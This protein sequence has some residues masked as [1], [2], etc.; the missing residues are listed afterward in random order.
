MNGDR[1]QRHSLIEWFS[2]ER[3]AR[4]RVVVVGAGAVGNEVIKN[5]ALLGVGEIQIYDIDQI[6]EHNLT[7]SVLFREADIGIPKATV[8]AQRAMELDRNV[9]ATPIVA[10]FWDHL[11]IAELQAFDLLLCCVDNFEARIRCNMISQI[12]RTDFVNV[13]IDSRFALVELFPFSEHAD[14]GCYECNLPPSVYRRMA[15]RYSCGHLRKLSL[16]ERKVPTTIITSTIAGS[17]AV[18]AGLRLGADS[19][20][21]SA[22]RI[23]IDTIAGSL[24]NTELSR[25]DGCPCCDRFAHALVVA[26]CRPDI[27]EWPQ[28]HAKDLT[29]MTS[30]PIL[31]GYVVDK[32][33]TVVFRRA[34]EFDSHFPET[35]SSDPGAVSLDIRDQFTIEELTRRFGDRAMPCKFAVV[36]GE[37]T[38][39]FEFG[40]NL[41]E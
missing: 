40:R 1:Y 9:V 34:S 29:V 25:V 19:E 16:A 37:K 39:I 22:R 10:D 2:Q 3:L 36:P 26:S 28:D 4:T 8:A 31:V 5:L 14:R 17:I 11:S 20:A 18:S 32:V 27:G 24:T 35:L 33:G 6:E 41:H 7:R 30:E 12:A 13:G 21:R 38:T 15:E 23:Y